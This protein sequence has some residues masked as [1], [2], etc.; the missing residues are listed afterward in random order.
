MSVLLKHL[1]KRGVLDL[2][3]NRPELHNAFDAELISELT[4]A[5]VEASNDAA[6]RVVVLSGSGT[7]FSAGADI[8]WMRGMAE[9]SE[10][11]N[12]MD[13]LQLAALMRTLNYLDRPT[14]AKISGA[15]FGGGLGLLACCDMT[16]CSESAKFGLTETTLGL[17]PAVISPYVFR[18]M[19]E[20]HARRYFL[21][22]ERFDAHK[23][24]QTGLVQEVVA[25][26]SLDESV[27]RL[28]SR[29]LKAAPGAVLASKKLLN[30][31]AG[32]DEEQQA[33]QDEF[34][35]QLIATLRVSAEGQEGLSAF[36]E[37]RTPD[38][39]NTDDG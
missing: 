38:W 6:V 36:L 2:T 22:G 18:K 16:I 33:E 21:S 24:Q 27:D 1:D 5:L 4:V 17:V 39:V 9:A 32:H 28:V 30:A 8:N 26:D 14:I 3:L 19:G 15:A 34:T 31:V 25:D 10:E 29:L 23:A 35:A 20:S 7:S 11:E 13:A 12:R 37:K